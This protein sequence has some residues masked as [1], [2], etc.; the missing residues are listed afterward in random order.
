MQ[1]DEKPNYEFFE[2][3]GI[4]VLNPEI[5]ELIELEEKIDMPELLK[6]AM[7]AN[8]TVK[9]YHSNSKMTDIGQWEYYKKFL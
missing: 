7:V 6:R 4:Y 3:T 9:V 2:N 5:V 1:I 8:K